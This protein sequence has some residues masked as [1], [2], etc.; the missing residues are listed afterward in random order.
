MIYFRGCQY[1]W[2]FHI[3]FKR[4]PL[5]LRYW[6]SSRRDSWSLLAEDWDLSLI[7]Y[8]GVIGVAGAGWA[9][10]MPFAHK[11][12]RTAALFRRRY[13]RWVG[14]AEDVIDRRW[15]RI[16]FP[17][18][19]LSRNAPPPRRQ[20]FPLP[21][22]PHN[23][24]MAADFMRDMCWFRPVRRWFHHVRGD[25]LPPTNTLPAWPPR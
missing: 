15:S 16:Y 6:A 17:S 9:R 7:I 18:A 19:P 5:P 11:I 25:E 1:W 3:C 8:F 24:V 14:L 21:C 22:I 13:G 10:I 4:G 12:P 2:P 23:R 20:L